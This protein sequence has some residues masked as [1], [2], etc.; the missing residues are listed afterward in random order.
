MGIVDLW[1]PLAPF[2]FRNTNKVTEWYGRI[3]DVNTP[4]ITTAYCL[5]SSRERSDAQSAAIGS[6]REP[7]LRTKRRH[8]RNDWRGKTQRRPLQRDR[9]TQTDQ[10]VIT[11]VV[12]E[13]SDPPIPKLL[14]PMMIV[15]VV[16]MMTRGVGRIPSAE[17]MVLAAQTWR[18]STLMQNSSHH[19]KQMM[20]P[21]VAVQMRIKRTAAASSLC[22]LHW[23]WSRRTWSIQLQQVTLR[24]H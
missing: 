22:P 14:H 6:Y 7:E 23:K 2:A 15:D 20:K 5:G 12:R 4:F 13:C 9:M 19:R 1:K 16:R 3:Y 21:P 24:I 18:I 17:R 8:W 10:T 11:K